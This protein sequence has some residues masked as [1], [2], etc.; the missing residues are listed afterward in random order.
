MNPKLSSQLLELIRRELRLEQPLEFRSEMRGG[1][2]NRV[3]LLESGDRQLVL[4]QGLAEE[5]CGSSWH[6]EYRL[7]RQASEGGLAPSILLQDT[8]RKLLVMEYAGEP[9]QPPVDH[10]M[11]QQAANQLA[12]LHSCAGFLEPRSYQALLQ[13]L[14]DMP[15]ARQLDLCPQ[16]ISA[17][18]EIAHQWDGLPGC[19]CHHDLNPGNLLARQDRLFV[20]DWE[21][22][23]WGNPAF[24]L[25]SLISSWMLDKAQALSLLHDH[26]MGITYAEILQAKKLIQ[27]F[28]RLWYAI[29][30]PGADKAR[31]R[32]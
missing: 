4:K 3:F 13:Q 24:D 11:L 7:H 5:P 31:Q 20:I 25:A 6:E 19:W 28:D 16:E 23:G 21:Y 22:S 14:L 9:V 26:A 12:Q 29:Y 30:R 8:A 32:C 27:L 18:R 17:V 1:S 15:Q 10:L 2:L